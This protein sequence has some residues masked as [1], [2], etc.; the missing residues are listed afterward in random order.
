MRYFNITR[1][2]RK[3]KEIINPD[4]GNTF[5]LIN[6]NQ[7]GGTLVFENGAMGSIHINR[8][9]IF[10]EKPMITFYGTDGIMMLPDPN[11]YGG[12]IQLLRKGASE[13]V[14]IPTL[15]GFDE[16]VRGLDRRRWLGL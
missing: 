12:E 6:E 7:M 16:N 3:H 13:A 9:S 2:E 4:F 5:T 11:A 10:P 14:R 8:D 15:H 1:K